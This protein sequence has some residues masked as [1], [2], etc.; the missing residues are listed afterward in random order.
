MM[1]SFFEVV[2]GSICFGEIFLFV[3]DKTGDARHPSSE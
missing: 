1:E 2:F 3:D